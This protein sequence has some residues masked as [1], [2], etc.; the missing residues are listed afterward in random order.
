MGLYDGIIEIS[1][2]RV[3]D[4]AMMLFLLNIFSLAMFRNKV[5]V[6]S[7]NGLKFI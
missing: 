1:F 4:D 3:D 5:K 7:S 6:S 2:E